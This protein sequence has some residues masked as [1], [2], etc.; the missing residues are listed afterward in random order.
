MP[1]SLKKLPGQQAQ[2]EMQKEAL[3]VIQRFL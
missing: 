3:V 1:A 2:I